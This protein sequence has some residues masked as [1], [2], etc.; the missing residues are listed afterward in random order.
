[1]W[2]KKAEV[3]ERKGGR[4]CSSIAPKGMGGHRGA[5]M[6]GFEN[7]MSSGENRSC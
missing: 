3:E 1:M 4:V 5:W 2:M 6:E 7:S